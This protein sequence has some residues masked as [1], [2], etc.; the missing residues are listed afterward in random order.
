[1]FTRAR[2][3]VAAL[4]MSALLL[5]HAAPAVAMTDDY[6]R[7]HAVP[8]L[9]DALILRPVGLLV[10]GLGVAFSPLPMAFVAVTRPTDI[11]EPFKD[12]VIRPA[13][14]TFVDPLGMH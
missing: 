6:A 13:R 11:L 12:L 4:V 3:V 14:Y 1:M 7:Q 10:T 8:V 5:A 9:F 2:T